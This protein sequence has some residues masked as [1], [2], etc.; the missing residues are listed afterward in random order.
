MFDKVRSNAGKSIKGNPEISNERN[1]EAIQ[2]AS[3][4]I[5]NGLLDLLF[6]GGIKDILKTFS[7]N[8]HKNSKLSNGIYGNNIQSLVGKF[9]INEQR[10]SKISDNIM[11]GVL[12]DLVRKTND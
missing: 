7:G 9:G 4:S 1:E 3:S 11:P 5:S 8:V 6:Q 12:T 10:A 2:C